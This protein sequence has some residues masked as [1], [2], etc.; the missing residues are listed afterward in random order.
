[1]AT[2]VP[3][4]GGDLHT[5]IPT[6]AVPPA[7]STIDERREGGR[8]AAPGCFISPYTSEFMLSPMPN[9]AASLL[10]A[11]GGGESSRGCWWW[12]LPVGEWF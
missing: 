4:V 9:A 5:Y 12:H 10:V 11:R 3:H 1:M 8:A 2:R 7:G 6:S